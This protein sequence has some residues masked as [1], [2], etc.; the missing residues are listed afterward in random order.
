[1]IRINIGENVTS[2]ANMFALHDTSN[3]ISFEKIIAFIDNIPLDNNITDISYM[4]ANQSAFN[5]SRDLYVRDTKANQSTLKLGR[6]HKVSNAR[7]AFLS[8]N[9]DGSIRAYINKLVW[10][11][12]N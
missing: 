11:E 8:K 6:F 2:L 4:F 12:S 7:G 3:N 9:T 5:L 10:Y 1:M